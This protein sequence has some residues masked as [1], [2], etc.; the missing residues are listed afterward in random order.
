MKYIHSSQNLVHY[1]LNIF[2]FGLTY[3]DHDAVCHGGGGGSLQ[4][5]ALSSDEY[6]TEINGRGADRVDR[7][8]DYLIYLIIV[9][10]KVYKILSISPFHDNCLLL[11][12]RCINPS[13]HKIVHKIK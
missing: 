4:T 9:I 1:E 2:S 7:V 11:C 8:I 13:I 6:I 5:V 10:D 12:H 3:G